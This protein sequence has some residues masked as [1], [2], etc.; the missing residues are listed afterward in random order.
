MLTALNV[1]LVCLT[2]HTL[3]TSCLEVTVISQRKNTLGYNTPYPNERTYLE[4]IG[5]SLP[6][7]H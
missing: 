3:R 5:C 1:V 6:E 4:E 2:K 7:D